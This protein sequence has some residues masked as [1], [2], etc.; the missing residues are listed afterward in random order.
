MEQKEVIDKFFINGTNT[1]RTLLQVLE[2]LSRDGLHVWLEHRGQPTTG[3]NKLHRLL[4]SQDSVTSKFL[5]QKVDL[6]KVRN[7]FNDQ[8]LPFAFKK[9]EGGTNLFFKVKDEKLAQ[10]ALQGIFEQLTTRPG[11]TAS[12]LLKN[13]K[14]QSF[15]EKLQTSQVEQKEKLAQVSKQVGE[16]VTQSTLQKS[17]GVG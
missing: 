8:G 11:E 1:L 9:V 13:P 15:E 16:N 3:E 4:Q 10:K 5:D 2:N 12:Q 14:Q 6:N 7:Y 17:K